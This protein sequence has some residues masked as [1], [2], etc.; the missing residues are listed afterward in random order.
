MP[1][2][3]RHRKNYY[4]CKKCYF[5][6]NLA[7]DI[8]TFVAN[9]NKKTM[10]A[11]LF[12]R[13]V[14]LLDLISKPQ[15]KTFEEID[16]AWQRSELNILGEPLPK[17]TLHNH[18]RAIATMFDIEI[19]CKAKG[20]YRYQIKYDPDPRKSEARTSLLNQLRLSNAMMSSSSI[21]GR[22]LTN[23]IL[24]ERFFSPLMTAMDEDKNIHVVYRDSTIDE[25]IEYTIKHVTLSP[26]MLRQ[27][28]EFRWYLIGRDHEDHLIHA[29]DLNHIEHIGVLDSTFTMPKEFTFDAFINTLDTGDLSMMSY[30]DSSFYTQTRLEKFKYCDIWSGEVI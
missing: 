30:D 19:I 28:S 27:M 4:F 23:R 9:K 7:H 12:N 13:Y 1:K 8:N 15:G 21:T 3:C 25:T 5:C 24:H 18:I 11:N 6:Q 14:W 16:K 29:L 22:I 17:R 26:Y 10:A 20:G 2:G